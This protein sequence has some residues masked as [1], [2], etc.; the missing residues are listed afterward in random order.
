MHGVPYRQNHLY[1]RPFS[2]GKTSLSFALAEKYRLTV[3]CMSLSNQ[4]LT[5]NNFGLLFHRL[6]NPCIILLKDTDATNF[7]QKRT[8]INSSNVGPKKGQGILLCSL[9]NTIDRVVSPEGVVLIITTNHQEK[10]DD[11]LIRNNHVDLKV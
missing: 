2:T 11:V 9:L 4:M 3:H 7:I 10:L 6:T 1:Y 8:T 5:D